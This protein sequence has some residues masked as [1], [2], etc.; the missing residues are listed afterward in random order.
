MRELVIEEIPGHA[1]AHRLEPVDEHA[2]IE[3]VQRYDIL[4]SPADGAFDRIT[5]LAARVLNTPIAIVSIVDTDRIWFKSHHGTDIE[6]IDRDS[7]LCASAILNYSPWIIED[8]RIDP[9]T[10]ANPLVA[11]EFG[12]QFYAGVPLTTRDGHNLGTLCVLDFA[13]RTL[14]EDDVATLEDLAA[15]VMAELE[16][17]LDARRAVTS[18]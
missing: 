14:A 12:L 15:M 2:R 9:H 1:A 5:R 10:L 3:A 6:Q 8:A 11:G 4:D 7:G 16:L 17:R 13:P 18:A